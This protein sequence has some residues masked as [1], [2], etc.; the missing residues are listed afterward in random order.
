MAPPSRHPK[1]KRLYRFS[2]GNSPKDLH[3]PS[4]A[5]AWLLKMPILR[6][7]NPAQRPEYRTQ[8][9]EPKKVISIGQH[10][11]TGLVLACIPDKASL[12][13]SWG[14]RFAASPSESDGW[15]SCHAL[16]RE[17]RDPSA[18]FH[19]QSGHY[20]EFRDG[21]KLSLF[22]LGA[23]LGRYSSWQDCRADLAREY[24][25]IRN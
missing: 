19:L 22:D 18:R 14:L 8:A 9:A 13:R 15:V 23:R 24:G 25:L 5:P 11:E 20:L 6:D 4:L 1:K 16:D 3:R 10:L 2:S 21:V 12:A 17:D 7:A